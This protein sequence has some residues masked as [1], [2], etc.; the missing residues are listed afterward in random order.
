MNINIG[1]ET[2]LTIP[3][4]GGIPITD[5]VVVSWIVS[6]III[7]FA[8]IVRYILLPKFEDVPKG[9]QNLIE[10]FVEWVYHFC[11]DTLHEKGRE[12]A[13]YIG[14]LA[15]YLGLANI[16]ELVGLKPPTTNLATT[17]ALAIMTFFLS[18]Y[19]GI[20][21][22]GALGRLKD[23]AKPVAIMA[24]INFITNL[25]QP[26]SMAS[27]LYGN[28]LGGLVVMEIIYK[29][30]PIFIPSFLAI[31]FNL[32]DGLMQTFIFMTLTLTFTSEAMD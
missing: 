21:K 19:Y 9:F 26:I 29:T 8:L 32:F 12:L 16:I 27:R 15:L 28:I 31:Y 17:F 10:L 24:P 25:A 6:V 7:A 11:E 13:P 20:R 5:A 3:I 2:W 22:K 30:V 23:L 4:F 1:T 18:N 14:T